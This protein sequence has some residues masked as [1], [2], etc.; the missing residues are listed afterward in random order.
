LTALEAGAGIALQ[1][2]HPRP[3]PGLQ[4]EVVMMKKFLVAVPIVMLAAA[5]STACA[6]KKFV[7][8]EVGSVNDKVTSLT[9][10][11]EENEQRIKGNEEK[12]GQV[13]TRVGQV[14]TKVGQVD[15]RAT[16][17]VADAKTAA[18]AADQ[19]AQKLSDAN[20]KLVWGVVLSEA[21]G[22][23]KFS[24]AALPDEAKTQLDKMVTDL[25]TDPKAVFF[26]I[27]G[28]TDSTGP[29]TIN[30][31]IGLDRAEAVKRYLYEQHNVPL[32]K[33]SVISY[34]ETKPV[35][36]NRTR[37]GRAKNRRIEV[38]VS[39]PEADAAAAATTAR[40]GTF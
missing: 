9:T 33:I 5:G 23:F 15:Q 35:D 13:D 4:W 18:T 38:K 12:I 31:Q 17:G 39:S 14:D 3:T 22:G 16:A 34:G 8:T 10:R 7:R 11:M 20:R 29:A 6:T 21:S 19:K 24:K 28:H 25:Q 37:D 27:E 32:H 1:Q 36:S 30:E 26:T 2:Q 40:T